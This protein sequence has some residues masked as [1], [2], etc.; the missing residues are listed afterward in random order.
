MENKT[1]MK[2]VVG[3]EAVFFLSL[4]MA[5]VYMSYNTGFEPHD[6]HALDIKSTSVYTLLLL[7]SS[8]T[9]FMTERSLQRGRINNLKGWLLLTILLGV[10]FLFGQGKEYYRL[11]NEQYC[12]C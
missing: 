8:F 6:V 7:I 11:I 2:L 5:F 12:M 3:T 1:M 10:A 4:I 9:F